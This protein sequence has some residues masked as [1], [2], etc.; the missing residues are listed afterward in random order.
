MV[1]VARSEVVPNPAK[2]GAGREAECCIFLTVGAEG[3]SCERFGPLD[4]ECRRRAREY[5]WSAQRVP[6]EP[7]PTC[8]IHEEER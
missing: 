1:H 5:G 7:W 3:F 2:C 4:A 6:E 8:M